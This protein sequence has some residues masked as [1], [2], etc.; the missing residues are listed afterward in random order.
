MTVNNNV[1]VTTQQNPSTTFSN[2]AVMKYAELEEALCRVEKLIDQGYTLA[3]WYESASNN[4]VRIPTGMKN[5]VYDPR[6]TQRII[7]AVKDACDN[8][9]I[10]EE[11]ELWTMIEGLVDKYKLSNVQELS[12]KLKEIVHD[13]DMLE[14]LANK[15]NAKFPGKV[16]CSNDFKKFFEEFLNQPQQ[17]PV[18]QQGVFTDPNALIN[19][20]NV[21]VAQNQELR[22]QIGSMGVNPVV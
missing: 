15:T 9:V 8:V 13:E 2:D 20:I 16:S 21:L 10:G 7:K 11:K 1:Q 3:E 22:K 18:Q 5:A 14:E 6:I 4:H 12:L 17:Q 19:Q